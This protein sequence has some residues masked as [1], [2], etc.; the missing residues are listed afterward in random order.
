MAQKKPLKLF[1][2]YS[3]KDEDLRDSLAEHLAL[4]KREGVITSFGMRYNRKL[5]MT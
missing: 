4:L 5:W 1:F 3:H 2:S